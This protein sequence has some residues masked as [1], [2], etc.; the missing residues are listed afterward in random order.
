M[1]Q[2]VE[3]REVEE[4]HRV[5]D[6]R[7]KGVAYITRRGIGKVR[8]LVELRSLGHA[9]SRRSPRPLRQGKAWL[10]GAEPLCGGRGGAAA[11]VRG[12]L[13]SLAAAQRRVR[14]SQSRGSGLKYGKRRREGWA[15]GGAARNLRVPECGR[16]SD[17]PGAV[18]KPK[19]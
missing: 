15:L 13:G 4:K 9:Y 6:E 10:H 7:R 17:V 14:A 19:K 5:V 12:A 2:L 8:L 11:A 18:K 3:L 1:S 16:P